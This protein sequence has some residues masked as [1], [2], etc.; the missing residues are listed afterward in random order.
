M[1]Q[2]SVSAAVRLQPKTAFVTGGGGGIGRAF[3]PGFAAEG[4]NVVVAARTARGVE[5]V[6]REIEDRGS[7]CLP[8]QCDVT[9]ERS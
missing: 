2:A 7:R 5:E 9:D 1:I 4:A 3:S 8:V 6:A